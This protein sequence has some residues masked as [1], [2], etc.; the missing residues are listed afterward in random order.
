MSRTTHHDNE[1]PKPLS[2]DDKH[3][4]KLI[5]RSPDRGEGW[6]TCSPLLWSGIIIPFGAKELIEL[7]EVNRRV[8]L[9]QRATDLITYGLI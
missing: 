1:G 9:T 2:D 7:D 5:A 6:R 8:R 3:T 4:L